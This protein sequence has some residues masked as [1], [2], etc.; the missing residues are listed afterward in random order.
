[1]ALTGPVPSAPA[2]LMLSGDVGS[3]FATLRS[4]AADSR[5][6]PPLL[7][8]TLDRSWLATPAPKTPLLLTV[9]FG[10]VDPSAVGAAATSAPWLMITGPVHE[11]ALA[12]R[13]AVPKPVLVSVRAVP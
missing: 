9:T 2:V 11:V 12:D 13:V 6:P 4:M 3:V 8:T 5:R 7:K 1:M 10:A